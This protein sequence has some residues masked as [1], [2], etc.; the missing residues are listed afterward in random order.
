MMCCM[1]ESILNWSKECYIFGPILPNI[2]IIMAQ[3]PFCVCLPLRY[4]SVAIFAG[5]SNYLYPLLSG[6]RKL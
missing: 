4:S 5:L 6:Y 3:I 1:L 2:A